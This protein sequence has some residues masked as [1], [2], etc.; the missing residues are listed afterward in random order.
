MWDITIHIAYPAF[1]FVFLPLENGAEKFRPLEKLR[2]VNSND[3]PPSLIV[4][5]HKNYR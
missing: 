1:P 4:T 2:T 5:W 3:R